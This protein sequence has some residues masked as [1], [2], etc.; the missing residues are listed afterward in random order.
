MGG[1]DVDLQGRSSIPG[2]W[3]CGEVACT[4]LHGANRLASN[5]L[6]E[7]VVC[8]GF[9]AESVAGADLPPPRRPTS[10]KL[11]E[12]REL[13]SASNPAAV[14]GAVS[15]GL[16][17]LR[18]EVGLRSTIGALLPLA[19]GAGQ[20]ADPALV[21]LMLAV[22]AWRRRERRG[23]HWRTDC[24]R[25]QSAPARSSLR[26]EEA[27]AAAREIEAQQAHAPVARSA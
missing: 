4:G 23:A 27:L 11:T 1:I 25:T 7:A 26:L 20:A 19:G 10:S 13:P 3:A 21:A 2:L 15:R 16:G 14:R 5:S 9:V 12:L 18:D 22:A 24:A 6:I 17:V 8:S